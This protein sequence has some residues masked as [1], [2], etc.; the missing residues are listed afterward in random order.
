[1]VDLFG[2]TDTR[3]LALGY[4]RI[5]GRFGS[6][7]N[8]R[9]LLGRLD[10]LAAAAPGRPIGIALGSGFESAPALIEEIAAR[11]RL[12]GAGAGTVRALK[13][14]V[15]FAALLDRLAIPHPPISLK[16]VADPQGWLLKRAGA[17]G[18][19]HIRRAGRGDP[20]AGAYF[21]RRVAGAACSF[22]FLADGHSA[23]IIAVTSQWAEP[24]VRTEF[25]YGGAL[26]P[27]PCPAGIRE[28]AQAALQAIVAATGLCGLAS[29]DCLIDGDRWWLLEINPRPG[30]TLDVLDRRP[31]PLLLSHIEACFGRLG[32]VETAQGA[33]A[34]TIIYAEWELPFA[35]AI[36]WPDFVMDRP[37]PG[38]RIAARAPICTVFAEADHPADALAS[39]ARRAVAAR[40]ALMTGETI[41][42]SILEPAGP[43][44]P[45]GAPG[46]TARR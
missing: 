11:H 41:D 9:S 39:L 10:E 31:T 25:R 1:V 28:A 6:G 27:G 45:R 33:A 14:P 18:G 37:E 42:A 43:Q 46:R 8:T 38:G 2:D 4:R 3:D 22:A 15:R 7:V 24:C 44:R 30:A 13:D 32:R 5:Q 23:R 12:L 19:G 26:D 40:A 21:Q 35:P 29:A 16:A 34:T 20:P 36:D 17:S